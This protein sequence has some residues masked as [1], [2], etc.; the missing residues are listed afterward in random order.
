VA[1]EPAARG[2]PANVLVPAAPELYKF[3]S[4]QDMDR[5]VRCVED[6][7]YRRRGPRGTGGVLQT[8]QLL[9]GAQNLQ[10]QGP[11]SV[12]ASHCW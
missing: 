11:A 7:A 10:H 4:Q 9:E 3:W 2:V 6:A 8:M 1:A 12:P 5:L